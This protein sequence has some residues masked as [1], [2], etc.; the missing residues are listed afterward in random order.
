ML[1]GYVKENPVRYTDPSGL[2]VGDG[3]EICQYY[4][5]KCKQSK[6]CG[7]KDN[8]AC[9]AKKCCESFKDTRANRCTRKCLIEKD[10]DVCRNKTGKDRDSCRYTAHWICYSTCLNVE[11]GWNSDFGTKVPP[12]C[13][14]AANAV[15]GMGLW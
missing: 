5:E 12:A 14:G 1:Y 6:E 13:Q 3:P 8:Y 11:E 4:E 9:E 7:D 15:G 2:V 10:I